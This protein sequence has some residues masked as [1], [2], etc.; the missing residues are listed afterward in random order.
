[1]DNPLSRVVDITSTSRMN[2]SS[3][4]T[5]SNNAAVNPSHSISTEGRN[6]HV[7]GHGIGGKDISIMARLAKG[8]TLE[9]AMMS[10]SVITQSCGLT[11]SDG[12]KIQVHLRHLLRKDPTTRTQ[13]S[14]VDSGTGGKIR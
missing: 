9:S 13:P 8:Q 10:L 5:D 14:Y 12:S 3:N 1:M 7:I 4:G 11:T 2:F 6:C